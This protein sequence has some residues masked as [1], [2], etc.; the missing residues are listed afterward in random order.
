MHYFGGGYTD[1]KPT[2]RN[3]RPF[4][5]SVEKSAGYGAGY[6]E[7]SPQAVAKVGGELQ[8]E[9]ERNFETIIG[10]SAFIFKAKTLF[11]EEWLELTTQLLSQKLSDLKSNPARHPLD[12]TDFQFLDGSISEYPLK[13]TELGGSILHPLVYRN[14]RKILKIPMNPSFINYR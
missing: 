8:A 3:W 1:I 14:D 12:Q 9:M 10:C 7:I 11:T 5:E 4:F 13:R 2:W 6:T